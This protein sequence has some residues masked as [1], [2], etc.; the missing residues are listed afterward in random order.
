[1]NPKGAAAEASKAAA[2]LRLRSAVRPTMP[3]AP[4]VAYRP[5]PTRAP[6]PVRLDWARARADRVP[7]VP[8]GRVVLEFGERVT[9]QPGEPP[10]VGM[11]GWDPTLGWVLILEAS[12]G[13]ERPG[14]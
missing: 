7:I 11:A 5:E 8:E 6:R 10:A 12:A 3:P 2:M 14:G 1:M 13:G 4:P 9:A